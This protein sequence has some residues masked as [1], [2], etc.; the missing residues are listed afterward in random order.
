MS[1]YILVLYYSR[2]GATRQLAERIAHGVDTVK[3]MEARLR[4]VP[5]VAAETQ[6]AK[7]P[8][9]DEGHPYCSEADL[10]DC[11]GLALGSPTRFGIETFPRQHHPALAVWRF[12]RQT[13][14]GLHVEFELAWRAR[15][16]VA[17]HDVAV[18]TPWHAD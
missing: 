6:T 16:H 14:R 3:G 9:P 10:R 13:R 15:N 12:G 4:G 8:V 7:P 17:E 2:Y 11:A 1:A 5:P 18:V